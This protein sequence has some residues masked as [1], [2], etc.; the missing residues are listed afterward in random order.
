MELKV[1]ELFH[2][3]ENQDISACG[4]VDLVV[5]NEPSVC[6]QARE[7]GIAALAVVDTMEEAEAFPFVPYLVIG[8]EHVDETTKLRVYQ[9]FHH[10][11]WTIL[12]TERIIVREQ[13]VS[14]VDA[15][16]EIYKEPSITRYT[17]PL[18]EDPDE[19]RAYAAQY[20]KNMY[21]IHE[22]GIWILEDKKNPGVIIGRAGLSLRGGYDTP[23]L[24]YII[25][26][27]YQR[28]GYAYEACRAILAYGKEE[29]GFTQVRSLMDER[30]EASIALCKKLG[31]T[32][33]FR[34]QI[35]QQEMVQYVLF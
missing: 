8:R 28:K 26:K 23:E 27:E 29:L 21:E 31:F 17:D 4:Q 9:R 30:N 1:A 35:G 24:G 12:E 16:Y 10:M 13:T 14:D 3:K 25:R 18:Y 11:P 32:Y 20:I 5:T 34:Q 19:E 2:G 15:L 6:L 22:H 7:L 33:D